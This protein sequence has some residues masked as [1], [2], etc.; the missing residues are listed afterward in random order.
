YGGP[1][2]WK[3]KIEPRR[4][5]YKRTGSSDKGPGDHAGHAVVSLHDRAHLPTGVVKFLGIHDI[6]VCRNLKHAVRGSI[7]DGI[8]GIE[9]M[10]TEA[11]D[12]FRSRSHLVADHRATDRFLDPVDHLGWKPLRISRKRL[13]QNEAGNLPM[14]RGR[15]L[16]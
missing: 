11:C 7:D 16:A 3:A 12:D 4:G 2:R 6:L 9:M 1:G 10:L 13:V 8:A 5:A 15:I 14:S